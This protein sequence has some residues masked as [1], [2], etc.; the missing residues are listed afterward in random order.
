MKIAFLFLTIDDINYPK[1][2][3][4]FFL[5]HEEK[6]N[7]YFHPKNVQDVKTEWLKNN[8][9]PNLKET[10]W[11]FIVD[12]YRSLCIEALKD[13]DNV[14]FVTISESCIPL[15]SF[16]HFYSFLKKDNVKTSYISY[17]KIQGWEWSARIKNQ[18][19]YD[20]LHLKMRKHYAR[21]CLSRYH[22]KKFVYSPKL[23][24][25][26]TMHVGDEFFL[27]VLGKDKYIK[28][29]TI[30][31]DNW[32]KTAERVKE[33][34]TKM[35][36]LMDNNGSEEEIQRLKDEYKNVAK[37]PYT[38]SNIT[39]ED[40]E[41][42]KQSG[43]FFWRKIAKNIPKEQLDLVGG[44]NKIDTLIIGNRDIIQ[45]NSYTSDKVGLVYNCNTEINPPF[46]KKIIVLIDVNYYDAQRL[47]NMCLLNGKIMFPK[48]LKSIF[49]KIG[50]VKNESDKIC[51]L[52][53]INNKVITF[54]NRI[55]EFIIAG[56]QKS[57][58]SSLAYNLSKHSEIY[59]DG[60]K[61]IK[62]SEIH[63]FDI[64]WKHGIQWYKNKF[65]YSFPVV[66]EKTPDLLNLDYTFPMIQKIN[67]YVKIILILRNPVLRAFS[68]WKMIN[69]LLNESYTFEEMMNTKVTKNKT[70]YTIQ[71]RILW[72]GY[73]WKHIKKLLKWFPKQNVHI[74]ILEDVVENPNREYKKVFDFLNV[75]NESFEIEKIHEGKKGD[76]DNETYSKLIKLYKKDIESLSKFMNR[77]IIWK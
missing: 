54:Q 27:S 37:N 5:G 13:R 16:D 58:T 9:V 11:G 6:Y 14:K 25:F 53:R 44:G 49:Q 15:Y 4:K 41:K 1:L 47:Y 51:S 77:D 32:D 61:N 23:Q 8:I 38:Y 29:Y 42:A 19:T 62:E 21:F 45:K 69:D 46:F 33:I 66:G 28:N 12:A 52:T 39:R 63:F 20:S 26:I 74:M 70:F 59:I 3:E 60:N 64:H 67:P 35:Y 75:K 55:V 36:Y 17:M 30:T 72:R 65:D 71:K 43:A 18:E 34:K 10:A 68:A 57:G 24:F 31:Y 2:W 73:Y 50:N 7:I 40:V 76:L 48:S 22:V 56:V